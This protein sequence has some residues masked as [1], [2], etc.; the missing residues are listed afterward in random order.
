MAS[1][2]TPQDVQRANAR[3]QQD[4]RPVSFFGKVKS[5]ITA[6]FSWLMGTNED[7][8]DYEERDGAGKRKRSSM[9]PLE[10][11]EEEEVQY[12]GTKRAP[13]K[14]VRYQTDRVSLS[15]RQE[16]LSVSHSASTLT[17]YVSTS[18]QPSA[19]TSNQPSVST[20]TRPSAS[21]R[22]RPS[23]STRT[24]PSV[25]TRTQPSVSTRTRPL[26]FN[27]GWLFASYQTQPSASASAQPS[28]STSAQPSAS[29]GAQ[30][31]ASTSAQPS[32]S[33]H[34]SASLRQEPLSVSHSASTLT[35]YVS[36]SAQPSASTSNQPSA[37]TSNQPSASI[38]AQPSVSTSAYE[39]RDGHREHQRTATTPVEIEEEEEEEIQYLGRKSPE[40]GRSIREN[41]LRFTSE[42]LEKLP[43]PESLAI[44]KPT[45]RYSVCF[46][47]VLPPVGI[48]RLFVRVFLRVFLTSIDCRLG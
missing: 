11:T 18:A 48:V 29:I 45:D 32:A 9:A 3:L 5:Y 47:P 2:S 27:R 34:V 39:E 28:A 19:S 6:P 38:S 43:G 25:S 16:P 26:A 40:L 15:L 7:T 35:R 1:T 20:R 21:T 36:T 44:H 17:R 41:G 8:N 22:T 4:P 23:V 10:S 14:R 13:I 46:G 31:S 33:D 12:L 37:S 42:A 24:R 30:P